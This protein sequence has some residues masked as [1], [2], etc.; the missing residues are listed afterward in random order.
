MHIGVVFNAKFQK[1]F[2]GV[3]IGGIFSQ[4]FSLQILSNFL[5]TES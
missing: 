2:L 4:S 5:S 1:K 3:E